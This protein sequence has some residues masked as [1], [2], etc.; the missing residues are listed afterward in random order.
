MD[1]G[2]AVVNPDGSFTYTAANYL[3]TFDRFTV[4]ASD[5][6]VITVNVVLEIDP[7][8][9]T[10]GEVKPEGTGTGGSVED[11][12]KKSDLE[13]SEPTPIPDQNDEPCDDC[14]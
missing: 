12:R 6:A 7:S 10:E 5:G 13:A 14:D 4:I 3:V 8:V 11:K 2:S 1:Q 9:P